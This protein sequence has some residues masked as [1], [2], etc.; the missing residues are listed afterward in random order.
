MKDVLL[1]KEEEDSIKSEPLSQSVQCVPSPVVV[2]RLGMNCHSSRGG[3]RSAIVTLE[4]S[5]QKRLASFHSST[6]D[7]EAAAASSSAHAPL[8]LDERAEAAKVEDFYNIFINT[9]IHG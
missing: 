5:P 6:Q 8:V 2:P 7:G 3:G 4:R 1:K 9:F